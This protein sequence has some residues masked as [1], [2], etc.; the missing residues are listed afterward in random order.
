MPKTS[1]P[2]SLPIPLGNLPGYP[3]VVWRGAQ[4]GWPTAGDPK[5]ACLEFSQACRDFNEKWSRQSQQ[6]SEE[7]LIG[8][9]GLFEKCEAIK[10]RRELITACHDWRPP[11]V[12]WWD[13]KYRH[14]P[15]W[16]E[17]FLDRH[18]VPPQ[19]T[20]KAKPFQWEVDRAGRVVRVLRQH[21]QGVRENVRAGAKRSDV[22]R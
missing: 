7:F 9:P 22:K 11:W 21:S 16:P 19:V 18:P 10:A 15:G 8:S 4:P 13:P 2:P 6:S 1:T 17:A 12:S 3:G 14:P 5:R 20:D